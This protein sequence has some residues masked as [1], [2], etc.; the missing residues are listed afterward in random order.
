MLNTP[1]HT[2]HRVKIIAHSLVFVGASA[3]LMLTFQVGIE[4]Q[5]EVA[6]GTDGVDPASPECLLPVCCNRS[7]FTA[8]P[9]QHV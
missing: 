3:L 5:C 8:C 9:A 6:E 2:V 1:E 4:A 7:I